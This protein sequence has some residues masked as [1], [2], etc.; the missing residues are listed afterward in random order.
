MAL[1]SPARLPS[2]WRRHRSARGVLALLVVTMASC[3]AP[4]RAEPLPPETCEVLRSEATLLEGGGAGANIERGAEWGKTNLSPEQ[5]RYVAR[6]IALRE[7]I[8]F[9]CR[10]AMKEIPT[11]PLPPPPPE[12]AAIDP[13]KVPPPARPERA[14]AGKPQ[15]PAMASP[16]DGS[17]DGARA[18]PAAK[19]SASRAPSAPSRDDAYKPPSASGAVTPS[20]APSAPPAKPL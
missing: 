4:A 15:K 20:A 9:R 3:P 19:P 1:G 2:G 6:L 11:P 5:I 12:P 7:Q 17:K 13:D 14:E 18:A 10:P 16:K 8:N